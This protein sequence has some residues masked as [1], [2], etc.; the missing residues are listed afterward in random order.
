MN[1]LVENLLSAVESMHAS[2][3]LPL[4]TKIL[5]SLSLYK[6]WSFHTAV[7]V[8][9]EPLSLDLREVIVTLLDT[10]DWFSSSG[11]SGFPGQKNNTEVTTGLPP[12][13]EHVIVRPLPTCNTSPVWYP[14]MTGGDSGG[15]VQEMLATSWN[16]LAT[17][18]NC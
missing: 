3:N 7:Q 16:L 1:Y 5:V 8:H 12:L 2:S 14:W 11:P 9:V 13:T 18:L 10:I 15:S 6:V 4:T 17:K